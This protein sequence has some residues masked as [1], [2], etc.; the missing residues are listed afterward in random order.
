MDALTRL[1]IFC[2]WLLAGASGCAPP[3]PPSPAFDGMY[4]GQDSLVRGGGFLCGL[5]AR[6]L[7]FTIRNGQFDYPFQVAPPRTA[8][9]PVRVAADGTMTGVLE[10]G[11]TDYTSRR[12]FT[13]ALAIV[14]GRITGGTL[15]ATISDP[16]CTRRLVAR[17]G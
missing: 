7:S 8:P 10:Y 12:G 11:A 5:P 13:T 1:A 15:E 14:S 2:G 6:D 16:R 3:P 4:A 9:L 17:R